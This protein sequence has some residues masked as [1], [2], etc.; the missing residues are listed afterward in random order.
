MPRLLQAL[1]VVGLFIGIGYVTRPYFGEWLQ[2]S[3]KESEEA[4]RKEMGQW[5]AVETN[6][7]EVKFDQPV[8]STFDLGGQQPSRPRK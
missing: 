7:Q 6:F 1:V 4:S 2:T 3:L 8:L 5:K